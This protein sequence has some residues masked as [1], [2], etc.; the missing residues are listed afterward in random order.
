MTRPTISY[1]DDVLLFSHFNVQIEKNGLAFGF[2]LSFLW[3]ISTS[4]TRFEMKIIFSSIS[5]LML[6]HWLVYQISSEETSKNG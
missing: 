2:G 3:Q 1:T 4:S 5:V 6:L